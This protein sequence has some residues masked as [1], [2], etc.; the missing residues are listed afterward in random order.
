MG[1]AVVKNPPSNAGDARDMGSI[2]GSGISHGE[3]NDTPLQYPCLE[4]P[5]NRGAWWTTI[6]GVLKEADATM[7]ACIVVT[8]EG[9]GKC[10]SLT[11][12]VFFD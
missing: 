10:V 2:T 5:I 6:H 7:H 1:G 11:E 3:G 12:V 8:R 4:N 9:L